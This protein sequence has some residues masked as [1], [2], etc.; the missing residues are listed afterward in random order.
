VSIEIEQT[1]F[2]GSPLN[3][4]LAVAATLRMLQLPALP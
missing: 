4:L 1:G 3:K 2:G